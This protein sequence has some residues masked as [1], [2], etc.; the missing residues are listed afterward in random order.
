MVRTR[1][2]TAVRRKQI[3]AAARRLIV[4]HGSE[5]VTVR[6]IAKETKVSEGDIYRHFKSKTDILGLLVEDV[7]QTLIADVET[8]RATGRGPLETL[9]NIVKHVEKRKGVSF[10][11]IAEIISFGDKGLNQKVYDIIG[12]YIVSI[13]DV[14]SDGVR[15][16]VIASDIDLDA[17]A[18]L[19][20]GM[21]QGLVNIWALSRFG[22]G[23]EE[24][25]ESVFSVFRRAVVR[26]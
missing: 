5:H 11:V 3:V 9:E 25:F 23:L 18:L 13:R 15:S 7:E 10:Q 14:L 26:A 20:F 4:R 16:G 17:S 6:R 12:R 19:F 8:S 2:S 21:I 22:P 24:Q 1:E